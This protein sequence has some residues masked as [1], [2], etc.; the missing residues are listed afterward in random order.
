MVNI[1][2]Q[3]ALR[4]FILQNNDKTKGGEGMR[5]TV[6][7]GG[8]RTP[9]GKFGGGLSSLTA[10]ELGGIAIKEALERA[11]VAFDKWTKS[12]WG[13]YFK[14]GQGQ[15]P[16]RQAARQAGLPWDVKTETIN[17]VCASGIRSVTLS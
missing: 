3:G 1:A 8:V 10:S 11:G 17:K 5:K 14:A 2:G 6:I 4:Y 12:L 7:V 15:I 9:F 13:T 16:S